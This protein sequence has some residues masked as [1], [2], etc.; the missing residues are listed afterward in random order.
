MWSR[1]M[2]AH[3]SDPEPMLLRPAAVAR[4]LGVSES[5]L[6]RLAREDPAFPARIRLS[7]R[8]VA[9]RVA[10]IDAWVARRAA[11]PRE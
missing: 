11:S 4:R 1:S 7:L 6:W 10:D 8:A 2:T 3:N 5:T 9:W